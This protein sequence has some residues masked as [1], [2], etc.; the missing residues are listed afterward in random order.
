M[1]ESL[2]PLSI[3]N[4]S[5]VPCVN[6]FAMRLSVLEE[7]EI[8]IVVGIPFETSTIPHVIVPFALILASVSV[9]HHSLT[10][11]FPTSH[12]AHV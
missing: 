3:I 1:L 5:V 8:R 7:A 11:S 9:P 10:V 6:T 12:L 2:V 4:F